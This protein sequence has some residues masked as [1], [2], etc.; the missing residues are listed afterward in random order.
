MKVKVIN[1]FKDKENALKLRK[2]GDV[3]DVKEERAKKLIS[4]RLAEETEEQEE[5]EKQKEI[6]K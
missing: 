3:L 1:S 4:M 6:K 2:V 5:T